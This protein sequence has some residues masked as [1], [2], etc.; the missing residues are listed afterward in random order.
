MS[1]PSPETHVRR[2]G[3]MLALH[4]CQCGAQVNVPLDTIWKSLIAHEKFPCF[5]CG[6]INILE[7]DEEQDGPVFALGPVYAE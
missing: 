1:T 7:V 4:C 2:T 6:Q 3:M 5:M